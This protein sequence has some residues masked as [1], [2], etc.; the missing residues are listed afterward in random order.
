MSNQI[1]FLLIYFSQ[2]LF[3]KIFWFDENI[4]D[5]IKRHTLYLQIETEKPVH[6]YPFQYIQ[7]N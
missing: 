2:L 4:C 3:S 5:H 1:N 6:I 7:T